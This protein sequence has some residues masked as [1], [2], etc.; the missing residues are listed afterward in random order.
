MVFKIAIA[1]YGSLGDIHPYMAIAQ[2]FKKRGNKVIFATNAFYK[3]KIE[4][5]GLE[6]MPVRPDLSQMKIDEVENLIE[7]SLSPKG[8]KHIMESLILPN[9]KNIYE[10]LLNR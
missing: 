6:F 10:D 9:L 5:E 7:R 4:R 2:E 3:S 8:T 1:S